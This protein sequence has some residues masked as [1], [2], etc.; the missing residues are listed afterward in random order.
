MNKIFRV[1]WNHATQSWIAVSELSKTKGKSKSSSGKKISLLAIS[2]T[3]AGATLLGSTAQAAISGD[4]VIWGSNS[5]GTKAPEIVVQKDPFGNPMGE[6]SIGIAP[7]QVKFLG[8]GK[9][10]EVNVTNAT[11]PLYVYDSNT[12][13]LLD[14]VPIG[15][16]LSKT[17]NTE[18][19]RLE[20][21]G[22]WVARPTGRYSI[23]IGQS[24]EAGSMQSVTLGRFSKVDNAS[25]E[26]YVIGS[27]SNVTK[28][29][30]GVQVGSRSNVNASARGILV[31]NRGNVTNSDYASAIGSYGVNVTNSGYSSSVGT[32]TI[33]NQSYGAINIGP[34]GKVDNSQL[35]TNVGPWSEINRSEQAI[36]V[37]RN[38]KA[39]DSVAST[40]VGTYAKANVSNNSVA[41]GR[42]AN[43]DNSE[44]GVTVGPYTNILG[45]QQATALGRNAK[46][47]S[48]RSGVAL[49]TF[50]VVNGSVSATAV[51]PGANV[52]NSEGGFSGGRNSKVENSKDGTA[53]GVGA[54]ISGAANATALGA[55]ANATLADSVALG[56]DAI[57]S[58]ATPTNSASV[59]G[60]NYSGF[61]GVNNDT[62]YVVSVGKNGGERQVQN[63]AAGRITENSTDAING[64]QLYHVLAAGSWTIGDQ[65][66]HSGNGVNNV[67]FGDR[68]DF[69]GSGATTVNVSKTADNKT[70]VNISSPVY[71]AGN[72]INLTTNSDG[73]ITISSLDSN[74][75]SNL[76][77]H[78]PDTSKVANP[79]GSDVNKQDAPTTL[80]D[81]NRKEAATVQDVLNTGWNLQ[82]NGVEKDFVAAYDTVNFANGSATDVVVDNKDGKLSNITFNVK[83]DNSTIVLDENGNLKA[84]LSNII[85]GDN[86]TTEANN[87]TVSVKTG[88]VTANTTTGKAESNTANGTIAK[89]E[90]VANAINHSGWKTNAKDANGNDVTDVLVNPGDMV[91]YVDGNGTKA[92][93]TVTKGENGNPDTFNV[94]YD[95][96]T[97]NAVANTTTGKAELPDA[98][99]GGDT[100][101]ATT[102]TNLVNNVFHTVNA[103]NKDE[104][105]EA[106]NGTTTVKAGDTIDFVAGKNLVVNQ[107]SKTIAFGLSRDIDVGNI[108]A[109]NVTVGD[110]V[111]TNGTLSNLTSHLPDTSKVATPSSDNKNE[112]TAPTDIAN[113]GN[114]AATV[115]DVLNAGWNLQGNGEAKD[116][117]A[118]YDTV[119]FA[120]GTATDVVI[121]TDGKTSNITFNVKYDNATIVLDENGNLKANL[122]N[123]INGDNTTT[124]TNNGTVSVKTGDVTANTTTGKAESNTTNGTIAKVEDVAGAI[125]GSGWKT[126]PTK[127]FDKDGNEVNNPT[128]QLIN[129]GDQVNY[130]NGNG[131]KAN[132]TVTQG[133]DGK[134]TVNVSYDIKPADETIAVTPEGVKVNT[135]T[136]S[137]NDNGTVTVEKPNL[138]LN[139]SEVA[140]LVNNA[141]FNVTTEKHNNQVTSGG[142]ASKQV[143]AGDTVTYKAGKNLE[144]YQDGHNITYGLSENITVNQANATTLTVGNVSDSSAPKVDFNAEK[145][146]LA[147]V[148]PNATAPENALNITTAGKPTQI[149]GV[150]SVLNLGDAPTNTGDEKDVSGNVT[151]AGT[152]GND[153]LVNLTN[154]PDNTLNSAATVRDLTN[155]G[156]VVNA[157]DN[158][159]TNTVKNANKVDFVGGD[160]ITVIGWNDGAVRKITV[161]AKYDNSTIVLDEN[162]NLKANV[163]N[164]I[165]GDNTTTEAN[166]GT[167]SVKTGDVTANSTTGKAEFNTTNGTIAKVEDVAGAINDSGWK[168]NAKDKDGQDV[169]DA[170]VNPGDTVNYVD[171]NGTKANVTITK[172]ERGNPDV[173]NVTYDVNTT[174]AVTNTT[175]GKAEL[176]DA[177]KGGD[178]LNATTITNLV[179]DVFH[180]VNATN[181][182]EQIEATNGT[183]TVKAGDTLNF[184]AGKN[185]VV[186]QTDKTIAFGLSRDIDV[187]NITA[188]NVTVGNTTIT[189]GTISGLNP[190]LPNTNNNDEYKVG[191]EI[192]KSQTLPSTLNITNAATVG[193]IL[194]SGW[195]LQNNGQAR[196][197]VKPYDSVNFVNGTA[198]TAV[199]ETEANGTVSNVTYNVNVDDNT[200]KVVD[201]KLVAN[202]TNIVNQVTGNSTVTDGRANATTVDQAGNQVDNSNKIAT[203]GDIVN[204]INNVHWNATAGNV[205]G[206]NGEFSSTGS[207]PIKAGDTVAYNAGKNIKIEQNGKT[208]NI[209]T[210]DNVTFTHTNTTTLTVGNVSDPNHSTNITSG[211]EGLNVNG[212]KITG[213]ANGT[214]SDNSSDAVNGSQLY[215]LGDSITNIFGGNTTFNT[216]TGK[217]EGFERVLNTTGLAPSENY[218][219]PAAATNITEAFEQLNNYVNAG[220]KL[221]N[222][223]GA[224]VE[225]ISPDEQVNFVDSNT[226]TSTVVAND[227][228]GAN[229]S[230]NVNATAVANNAAG[231]VSANSTTGK[232]EFDNHNNTKPLAT[233]EDVAKTVNNTGWFMN[234]T[235]G[236]KALVNPG[237]TVNYVDGN[238][239]KANVT[240]TK[241]ANGQP[242]TFNV[243]YDI[244]SADNTIAVTPEGVKVNTTTGSVNDN[245]TVK[246]AQPDLLLNASEVANLVNNSSFNATIGR[247][248]TDF[249]DQAGKDNYKVKAGDTI[250]FNAGKN[251]RVKQEN[252]TF[253]YALDNNITVNHANATTLTV[254]NVSNPTAPKVDFNAEQAK[255]ATNNQEAPKNALNIT[256]DGKPT[257]ITGVGSTLNTTNVVT[258]PDGNASTPVENKTLVDLTNATTPDSAATVRDLQNMGWVI[259][260]SGN[261]YV[262]TVK[263]A[264]HVKF[265]GD[266]AVTVTGSTDANGTRNITVKVN[267]TQ[268]ANNAAG[269]VYANTTTGKVEFNNAN[270][271]KPLATV[272]DVASAINGSG[273]ELNSASVG[274]E[275][276]GDTAPTRVNP[277]SKVNINAGKNVVITRSG[278]DITIAT[279]AKPVFENVQVGGDKGPI[280]GGDANGDVKVSKADGSPTKVTNVAAGTASTDAVNVGQLKG[281]VG[282]INNRM[283]K[284]NKDLRG[285]IAGANAAAGLPQVYIP[286]KSM[287]AASAGTFKGQS[288]VAVGY[289][290]ASDNGK[291]ILKLQGNA[292]TRGDLGGSVGVGYQW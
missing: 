39:L 17:Y 204:T 290:R 230:F 153:Q 239:T 118:A 178:T 228:G 43:V 90:D 73:S 7:G 61:A 186:N 122:S 81:D 225:R 196:D 190:N 79:N 173:F 8:E 99:K 269:N 201:G 281:T 234:T 254:G 226:I 33:T 240:V 5:A 277:G 88:D 117:V 52:L 58:A 274:G 235:T 50:A 284:M 231:N 242:D 211:P 85:N 229:I 41:V 275:V 42:N 16:S 167:V 268:M 185:L 194:N 223:S 1:I 59:N 89:V 161:T 236:E 202:A 261:G 38:A 245:G 141:S 135:T 77:S 266:G 140:N 136:G 82:G 72:N 20:Y 267:A 23:S 15:G 288:A 45:S 244:K 100:L 247:D 271:S 104:Q 54:T 71:T 206:T 249:V 176:P 175:T 110:T 134:D 36:A 18:V 238:G 270:G 78:L 109:G 65:T 53:L 35:A 62:N 160:A 189:N 287:V 133:Q 156:W 128:D 114:E 163:S 283:N 3:T 205:T 203:V 166:N 115:K 28:S 67:R 177:T 24:S 152:T 107:T 253:T 102:I 10:K 250:T 101:N 251:L 164:I 200:I 172:G 11:K 138:L 95:V 64:S 255:P 44:F 241:G 145:A 168:T 120:N 132:V 262:D 258:N 48:S 224:V 91:N 93:V 108:T 155:L 159:Y 193:D 279:S 74:T 171:G 57:T 55:R 263:N 46:V 98:T 80:T 30:Q 191:D 75:L 25:L 232:A 187:G 94:T 265:S 219:I 96:N 13:A 183:T 26:G 144:V 112:Q 227:K 181:K 291:L 4:A 129:P 280:V 252:G 210:T 220:W 142:H 84:N 49:G 286:G 246:V 106:T 22:E 121:G 29:E 237:D 111:L 76:T 146:T 63:V 103:T 19:T 212:D 113:K 2:L 184:V 192:T 125:N 14:Y 131:T 165:N 282:N 248:D 272:E 182:D 285:G 209:S 218:T 214:I 143:K 157:S 264:N 9:D 158:N 188:D 217:V 221:G 27:Q 243:T 215:S 47:D 119:N 260:T 105:I 92:N 208:F 130:V 198:T 174:N 216:T 137:V 12:G 124:E 276:I 256:T 97:T 199:V 83:Y 68:V 151:K 292:N 195:N 40:V 148:N 197:F 222:A 169:P 66:D 126:T 87:G 213:V 150:G 289:S 60:I 233:V 259:E 34:H 170:L 127:V 70:L 162:G 51:G 69:I 147:N 257:Q 278:K 32:N 273:W 123:V 31:G 179:N 56:A 21:S 37:G 207:E 86:T 6:Y 180:T 154:L 149:T 139:A 116:F